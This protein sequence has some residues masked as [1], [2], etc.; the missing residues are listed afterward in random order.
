MFSVSD[1]QKSDKSE[2]EVHN[3]VVL[4]LK[5][6]FDVFVFCSARNVLSSPF[7]KPAADERYLGSFGRKHKELV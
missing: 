7:L 2:T 6:V 4:I 1:K 3:F 5:R